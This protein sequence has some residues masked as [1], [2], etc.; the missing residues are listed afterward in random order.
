MSIRDVQNWTKIVQKGQVCNN[1]ESYLFTFV[2]CTNLQGKA[3]ELWLT[4]TN[5]EENN[6]QGNPNGMS[7]FAGCTKLENYSVIPGYRK[8][9]E[10]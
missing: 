3:P 1:V 5:S 4:G 6:Y 7:C 10:I 8:A 9:I 2:N